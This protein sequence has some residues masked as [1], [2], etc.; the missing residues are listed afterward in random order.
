M[1]KYGDIRRNKDMPSLYDDIKCIQKIL[2]GICQNP[3]E[4]AFRY[5]SMNL[6]YKLCLS[7]KDLSIFLKLYVP[8]EVFRPSLAP[9]PRCL[10]NQRGHRSP[11]A[12]TLLRLSQDMGH[13]VFQTKANIWTFP[14]TGSRGKNMLHYSRL[15]N[16]YLI[17]YLMCLKI[18]C[19]NTSIHRWTLYKWK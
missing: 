2:L 11:R 14:P 13:N 4:S 10:G 3:P 5:H 18:F 19:K 6:K 16:M 15:W 12:Q 17:L 1:P 8:S 7:F 9:S